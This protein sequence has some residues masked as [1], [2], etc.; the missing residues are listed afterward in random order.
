MHVCVFVR[1]FGLTAGIHIDAPDFS[2]LLVFHDRGKISGF[3]H[4][5]AGVI[6]SGFCL[7]VFSCALPDLSEGVTKLS[8]L[9]C[10]VNCRNETRASLIQYRERSYEDEVT[11]NSG[12]SSSAFHRNGLVQLG[13]SWS[14]QLGHSPNWTGPTRGTAE[15]NPVLDPSRPFAILYWSSLA[16][17]RA[18]SHCRSSSY[19]RHAEGHFD[20]E[21]I[22]TELLDAIDATHPE[23]DDTR[24]LLERASIDEHSYLCLP[25][26]AR[27][28][29]QT[30]LVPEIYTKDEINEMPYGICGA[31][32][33]NEDDFQMKLDGVYNP[34]NDIASVG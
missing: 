8:L 3:I 2:F 26:Q 33:K 21:S 4:V 22:D 30:K 13:H 17:R 31:L 23:A 15:L 19:D 1:R 18:E 25:E 29:T 9:P 27:S 10:L 12:R 28:F 16:N 11:V 20:R 34:L 14:I 6:S 5:D 32:E 24:S 7:D